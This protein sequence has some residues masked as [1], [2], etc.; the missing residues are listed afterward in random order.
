MWPINPVV[1]SS[2]MG[3]KKAINSTTTLY[4]IGQGS[5]GKEISLWYTVGAVVQ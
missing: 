5:G 1:V 2:L 4:N 3:V